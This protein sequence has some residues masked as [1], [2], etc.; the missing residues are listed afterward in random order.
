MDAILAALC[1]RMSRLLAALAG[2]GLVAAAFAASDDATAI[3]RFISTQARSERGVEYRSARQ[4]AT[5]ALA[6][7]AS[8]QTVVLYTIE[9][10]RG[11]NRHVQF[12]AVFTQRAGGLVP[13][14]RVAVGAK[15][16][17]EVELATIS[18]AA[19]VLTTVEHADNDPSCCPS[20][21]GST[22]YVLADGA[23]SEKRKVAP[24]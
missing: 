1:S 6:G 22:R 3:D 7:D 15:S 12:L 11:S 2:A 14:A 17:R 21:K 5:G 23:L 20:L 4:T 16:A 18:G 8:V 9:S 10:Q 19:I 13:L 24:R